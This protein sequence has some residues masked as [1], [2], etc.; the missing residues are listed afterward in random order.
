MCFKEGDIRVSKTSLC[1]LVETWKEEVSNCCQLVVQGL[2]TEWCEQCG[3]SNKEERPVCFISTYDAPL[4]Q[5]ASYLALHSSFFGASGTVN[6]DYIVTNSINTLLIGL[7]CI[8]NGAHTNHCW[9]NLAYA[10]KSIKERLSQLR[11]DKDTSVRTKLSHSINLLYSCLCLTFKSIN[12]LFRFVTSGTK[13]GQWAA[14]R[15]KTWSLNYHINSIRKVDVFI[16]CAI[17]H[18]WNVFQLRYNEIIINY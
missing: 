10:S 7:R 12:S 16:I 17:F 8:P 18:S 3:W 15:R 5:R 14:L 11:R 6:Y 1:H 2:T 13:Y 9:A 4:A